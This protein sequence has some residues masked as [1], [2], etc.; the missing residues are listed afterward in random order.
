M[1]SVNQKESMAQAGG[2][3]SFKSFKSVKTKFIPPTHPAYVVATSF[4]AP[5]IQALKE[6]FE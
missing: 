1:L 3:K 5:H 6:A 4:A 2:K